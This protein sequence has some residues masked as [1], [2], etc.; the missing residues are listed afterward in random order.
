MSRALDHDKPG[1]SLLDSLIETI[2]ARA[3]E[4]VVVTDGDLE[5][6]QGPRSEF[7]NAAAERRTGYPAAAL[8]GQPLAKIVL[9]AAWPEVISQ[10]RRIVETGE[11][12][13]IEL[14]ARDAG[15]KDYWIE[16]SII[17]IFGPE[18]AIRHFVRIGRDVTARKQAEQQRESAQRLLASV[19]GAVDS[20]L[21]VADESGI[22]IMSNAAVTRHLGW[23]ATEMTGKPVATLLDEAGRAVFDQALTAPDA[24]DQARTLEV[25]L[26]QRNGATIAGSL[27][28]TA[29]RQPDQQRHFVIKL[30][31]PAAAPSLDQ[32]IRRAMSRGENAAVVA[33]KLQL[34]GLDA[35]QEKLGRRWPELAERTLALAERVIRRY[36]QPGD[37]FCRTAGESF[38]VF[39]ER[40]TE[41]EAKFKAQAIGAEI[42]DRLIGEIPEMVEAKVASFAAT[43]TVDRA[44]AASEES[45]VEALGKRL[46]KERSTVEAAAREA[47][48]NALRT[49]KVTFQQVLNEQRKPAPIVAARLPRA[50]REPVE[51]LLAL[52]Q[53]PYGLE[54]EAFLLA[55]AGERIL[56][57]LGR[58][59]ADLVIVP[60]RFGTVARNRDL[61]AWLKVARNLGDAGRRQ[62][63]AEIVDIPRDV[64]GVRLTD[65]A[66][67]LSS[68][69]RTVAFEL[70]T[71]EASFVPALPAPARLVT[72]PIRCTLDSGGEVAVS[73]LTRLMKSLELRRC[74]LI[75]KDAQ[76]TRH[77]AGL[78]K[79]GLALILPAPEPEL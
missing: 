5:A 67:R 59:G 6:P 55:G 70:P 78:T 48:A 1:D 45:I 2:V 37:I 29:V 57:E 72:I 63:V 35:V 41:D 71:V 79:A 24:G 53:E 65:I 23:S 9:P 10:L 77:S 38:L 20:P 19:F 36:L 8:L 28:L 66:M 34:V 76:W 42:R 54:A 73:P 25:R 17:P 46:E 15:Q 50:L 22:V 21:I 7:I 40:L 26:V 13:R 61:E 44:D 56:A 4:T 32:A 58:G 31:L 64:A 62:V 16:L 11:P 69:F 33:G 49:V 74:R 18:G 68:L 14:L 60:V 47:A 75:A 39:F 27:Q 3:P 30:D 12:S 51:T 43:V 52:G